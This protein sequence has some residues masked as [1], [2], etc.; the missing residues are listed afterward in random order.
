VLDWESLFR[1][2]VWDRRTTPYLVPVADLNR[3]QADYEI[4]AYCMFNGVLFAV[5]AITALTD[6]APFGRSPLIGLYAFTVLCAAVTFHYTKLLHAAIYLALSP[7]ATLVFLAVYGFGTA[8]PVG[9]SLIV[10]SLVLVLLVYSW[11]LIRLTMIYP[12]LPDADEPPPRR[13]LFK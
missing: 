12:S 2:Y 10:T 9:D 3:S 8:R 5:V 6:A 1:R 13:R 7:L 4:F 11:R